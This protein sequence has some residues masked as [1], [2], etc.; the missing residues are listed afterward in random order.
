MKTEIER[1]F[2]V[3]ND[4]WRD[5]A[6]VGQLCEQGYIASGG[7]TVRVRLIGGKGVLTLKGR[8]IGIS[9]PELEYEI[10][11][12]EAEFMLRN[13]CGTR[14]VSK[15]RY[16]LKTDGICWEIDLF[17]GK[18]EGLTVAEIEL[19]SEDQPVKT[20]DWLGQEVSHDPRYFNSALSLR[21]F[22]TWG[23]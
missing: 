7:A 14:I 10:P 2:L 20:P 22:K 9:R 6:D 19:E 3:A 16:L 11:A 12:D 23:V 17:S 21:P 4:T 1:K 15:T 18:N 5:A 8:T 13:F